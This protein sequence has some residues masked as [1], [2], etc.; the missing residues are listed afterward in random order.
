MR[1]SAR[2]SGRVAT[3]SAVRRNCEYTQLRP[4]G[5][6]PGPARNAGG[7]GPPSAL[8]SQ[9]PRLA[10]YRSFSSKSSGNGARII[11]KSPFGKTT[12]GA[13]VHSS[14]LPAGW[15]GRF[16][17]P[18]IPAGFVASP[19]SRP[20][21]ERLANPIRAAPRHASVQ[22]RWLN[23]RRIVIFCNTKYLY[24]LAFVCPRTFSIGSTEVKLT[25]EAKF[26]QF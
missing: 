12:M 3:D 4:N 2:R 25:C 24:H 11:G 16:R 26:W 13:P 8:R 10:P 5:H 22:I 6:T 23:F 20:S 17:H 14:R 1:P 9:R 15:K 7:A 18:L 19:A 21:R